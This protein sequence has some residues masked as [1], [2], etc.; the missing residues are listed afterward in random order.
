MRIY[1]ENEMLHRHITCRFTINVKM[2]NQKK[3]N[4]NNALR[5]N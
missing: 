5:F 2:M 3:R 4:K 1:Q